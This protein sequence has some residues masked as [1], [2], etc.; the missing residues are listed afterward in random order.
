M[1]A[2][3]GELII[4]GL[5]QAGAAQ[6]AVSAAG[7]V[8]ANV[9]GLSISAS[10]IGST[11][12]LAGSVALSYA[13]QQ[14]AAPQQ[15][16][17][18]ENLIN[19][20]QPNPVRQGGYGHRRV[21]GSYM[22]FDVGVGGAQASSIDVLALV[23]GRVCGYGQW[24]L[25]EDAPTD[26]PTGPQSTVVNA[27]ANGQYGSG[28]VQLS[29][30]VGLPTETAHTS[31]LMP[32][33]WDASHRGDG[34]ASAMVLLT[35]PGD[36]N[37][38]TKI[39]PN[40]R[41]EASA[42]V[43]LYPVWDPRDGGQDPDNP[44]TWTAY[45]TYNPA[46]TYAAGARVVFSR[47]DAGKVGA[48]ITDTYNAGTTYARYAV[49]AKSNKVYYSRQTGNVGH[50]VTDLAWW[51]PTGAPYY[52]RVAGNVGNQ[53]DQH[54]DKWC[55]VISNPVLQLIDY[56]T[57]S[58]HGMGLDRATAITPRLANFLAKAN[59]CDELVADA[60]G[61][62]GPRYTANGIFA[63]DD[64]P[65]DVLAGIGAACDAWFCEDGE[66]ALSLQVGV[67]S[68]PA[69]TLEKRHIAGLSINY[70]RPDEEVVNELALTFNDPASKYKDVAGDPW[71]DNDD[72]AARGR[73]R[74][75][76]LT[77]P[78]VN[79]HSQLRRLAKRAMARI[80]APSGT[81]ALK[82]YGLRALGERW[83]TI[84]DDRIPELA[85]AVVEISNARVDLQAATLSATWTLVDPATIDAWNPATEEGEGPPPLS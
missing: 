32:S 45:P 55:L 6:S 34:I 82:L 17:P 20:R 28:A 85:N 4:F 58:D 70:G 84:K 13:L 64:D 80:S 26:T 73:V 19:I 10:V 53:P 27:L 72:I 47:W 51:L 83:V 24:Y 77:L 15:A 48:G 62:M 71:R 52:S 22:L 76:Q 42:E 75:Q 7:V 43:D 39:F 25:N 21:A 79:R 29:W 35:Q 23:S 78:W 81:I 56:L 60:T 18:T 41:P 74:S 50:P 2:T 1:A 65:A 49:V 40:G 9:L 33:F 5:V 67:Y 57:N 66:G 37:N 69:V 31:P 46:A 3:V 63:F 44:D 12:L 36:L 30:R 14:S 38:F 68:P 59:L 11:A 16:S 61:A 54:S 8:S